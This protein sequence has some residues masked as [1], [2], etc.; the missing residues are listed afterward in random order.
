MQNAPT[1]MD[2]EL[3]LLSDSG[4]VLIRETFDLAN[5]SGVRY[6]EQSTSSALT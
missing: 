5:H 6:Q 2:T 1:G 4:K 3:H